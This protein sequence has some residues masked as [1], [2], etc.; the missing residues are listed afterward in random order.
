MTRFRLL[1]LTVVLLLSCTGLPNRPG[2]N[3]TGRR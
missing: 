3:H 2:Y 1:S